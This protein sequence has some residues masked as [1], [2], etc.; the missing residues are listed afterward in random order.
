MIRPT[1]PEPNYKISTYPINRVI[2]LPIVGLLTSPKFA[3]KVVA[4]DDYSGATPV[5][6]PVIYL[7]LSTKIARGSLIPQT[8]VSLPLSIL[9]AEGKPE[10]PEDEF[11]TDISKQKL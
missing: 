11:W 5:Q 3:Y 9:V 10:N 8:Y 4:T 2:L 6:D 7:K 1:L